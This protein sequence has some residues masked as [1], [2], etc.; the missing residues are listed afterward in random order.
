MIQV[1]NRARIPAGASNHNATTNTLLILLPI[2]ISIIISVI[3]FNIIIIIMLTLITLLLL[4]LIIII[5]IIIMIIILCIM[6]SIIVIT[7]IIIIFIIIITNIIIKVPSARLR[8]DASRLNERTR[9]RA[10]RVTAAAA[11]A[12]AC[13]E[14]SV[15][16]PSH[17]T[18]STTRDCNRDSLAQSDATLI[19]AWASLQTK[20]THTHSEA[21]NHEASRLLPGIMPENHRLNMLSSIETRSGLRL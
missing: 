6:F 15:W 20:P 19:L 8:W 2:I 21:N 17:A 10:A 18:R 13:T 4:L 16:V 1:D 12:R 9:A 11:G 5:M 14:P 7:I 3:L